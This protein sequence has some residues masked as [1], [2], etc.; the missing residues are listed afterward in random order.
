MNFNAPSFIPN[1]DNNSNHR[2]NPSSSNQGR[3]QQNNKRRS[4]KV[5]SDV[6]DDFEQLD[7]MRVAQETGGATD[8]KGRVSLNHLL[9]F[10]FPTRQ[11]AQPIH[12]RKAKN[13][14]YQPFN[15]ERFMNANFRFILNPNGNYIQ[16][17][18]DP[19]INF[20]WETIEQVLISSS[21]SQFCPI[22]LS[23]PTAARVTKC[24]HIF[25]FPCILHYLE[26][27]E[28]P[29]KQWRKCP[30]CW[31]SIYESD[32][33]SVKIMKPFAVTYTKMDRKD[34]SLGNGVSEGDYISMVLM[35]RS[36]Q[37]KLAFPVSDTWPLPANV[38]YNYLKPD[39]PIIPWHFTPNAMEF[40]RFM[41]GTPDYL[42][43]EYVRDGAELDDALSDAKGWGSIEEIPFIERS[44][45]SIVSKIIQIRSQKTKELDLLIRT[46]EM[47]L[48]AVAKYTSK[49]EKTTQPDLAI[50]SP[51]PANKAGKLDIPEAY[52]Q[53]HNHQAGEL[54][55]QSLPKSSVAK[56]S[57]SHSHENSYT[58]NDY[59]FYQAKD[60]QHVYLHPLD[61][62]ILKHEYGSYDHFPPSIFVQVTNVQESTVD[63]D[64]RK[65]FKYL[66]HLPIACD[67][68][69][70]EIN[71]KELVSAETVK[72]FSNELNS[73]TKKKKD[74]ERREEQGK[75][76][77]ESKQKMQV[78]RE[79]ESQHEMLRNDPFFS[80]YTPSMTARESDEQ[81]SLALSES[82]ASST[83]EENT[84]QVSGPR[85]VWGTRQVAHH[86]DE[87]YNNE[88][89]D[90]VIVTKN[91]RKKKGKKKQ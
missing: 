56:Q 82:A 43:A 81:L 6:V 50:V 22:C 62:R 63:E 24:G 79:Q 25:C 87:I 86:E 9:S 31:E 90:H 65:K 49:H 69:F 53:Y 48:S 88:W 73:R 55:E 34:T 37:S 83:M 61:I 27:R 21:E 8:R 58:P 91:H 20:D 14:S 54:T 32:L 51:P 41:L 78:V 84:S 76:D 71:V 67:V 10:S 2:S 52:I 7:L 89:P 28:N 42:E 12:A 45:Q 68:T 4:K 85:T 60:G 59:Y 15:K 70:L 5:V 39:T 75:K 23:P 74:K 44:K 35:Q 13:A 11:P 72:H 18:V 77:A 29:K 3:R 80:M 57:T 19:D 17:L 66:G 46:F 1:N 33:K 47:M 64:L 16:Q 26:L 40:A 36:V 30:I 38:I